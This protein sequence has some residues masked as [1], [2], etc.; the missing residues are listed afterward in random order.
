M[1]MELIIILEM[2]EVSI[3]YAAC[4][5]LAPYIVLRNLL[6]GK[7]LHQIF[8]TCFLIG[9]FYIT[10]I[11][12]LIFL[13]HIPSRFTLYLA[14]ILPAVL[15][16]LKLNHPDLRSFFTHIATTFTRLFLGEA[17]IRTLSAYLIEH[18]RK[19]LRILYKAL[20]SHFFRHFLEW[21]MIISLM[22]YNI[23]YYGYHNITKYAYGA[24]DIIVHHYWI[25]QMDEG[26]IFFKG[27]YP[28]GFHNVIYFLH[29]FFSIDILSILRMF[30]VIEAL[31]IYLMI[32]ILLRKICHSRY[33]PIIAMLLFTLPDFYDFQATMRYQWALPQEFG[34]VFLYPCAYFLIQFFRRK[35]QEL[36]E[37]KERREQKKLYAWLDLYHLRPSTRSLIL[38]AI[39][40]SLTF[41]AHFYITI[42]AVFLCLAVALAYI[43]T[44][45]HYRYFC[46]IA[47]AGILSLSS[48]I[49]PL[50]IAYLQGTPLQG[51]LYWALNS[52]SGGGSNNDED[53]EE[54]ST[55]SGPAV[56]TET[57]EGVVLIHE[58]NFTYIDATGKYSTKTPDT[59]VSS[60]IITDENPSFSERIHTLA[61]KIKN[62]A[63]SAWNS[64]QDKFIHFNAVVLA[65]LPNIYTKPEYCS[66][67]LYSCEIFL[68]ICVLAVLLRRQSYT[69]NLL[70]VALYFLFMIVLRASSS[71]SLPSLMDGN[72]SRIFLAYATPLLLGAMLD[73]IYSLLCWPFKYH[74]ITELLPIASGA[75]MIYLTVT[76]GCVKPLNILYSL[77]MAGEMVCNYQIEHRYP[78]LSWTIVTTTNSLQLVINKGWHV[79]VCTFLGKMHN[80]TDRTYVTIPSKYVFFYIEKFPLDYAG[81][82][83]NP[84]SLKYQ[85]HVS[86][87]SASQGALFKGSAAYN[88]ENRHILESK[89]YYWAKAFQEK[90]PQEFQVFYEDTHFIC[91][92]IEQNEYHLYNFAIDYGFN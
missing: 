38:F 4:T 69:R 82:N 85:R 66:F 14:T 23:W 42:V 58:G 41:S 50:G 63:L 71:L 55:E 43:P 28:F 5:L 2:V 75:F 86:E 34:M 49:A 89:L 72:R 70:M 37:E 6:R 29:N 88:T 48:A 79:E 45:F 16:W 84:E 3:A 40:F 9:N 31:I 32:Y 54:Q 57:E 7:T 47:V 1:S 80:Y 68:A 61:T 36:A 24:P 51:S 15:A 20:F 91:Y 90:Y 30:G 17:K 10:N 73:F 21:G 81:I 83:Y 64:L 77:Q 46:P 44:V 8:I 35:R 59:D 78:D 19:Y 22:V 67:F 12:Y 52:M 74:R 25:N 65:I 27:V 53:E 26:V 39:S 62:T 76:L 87:S 18:G 92:R 60:E 33:I 13:L 56:G 11:V